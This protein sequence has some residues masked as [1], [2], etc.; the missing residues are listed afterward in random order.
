[1]TV[2][3]AIN[4]WPVSGSSMPTTAA[5][6]TVGCDTSELSISAVPRRW[7]DTFTTSSMRP[8]TQKKPSASRRAPSP[9]KY[10]PPGKREK[11]CCS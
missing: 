9:V 1:L 8:T 4:A 7:P 5:S 11:Y 3:N 6:A 10:T 2:T